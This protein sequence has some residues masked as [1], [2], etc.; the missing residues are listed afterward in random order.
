MTKKKYTC[1]WKYT[2][3]CVYKKYC[4]WLRNKHAFLCEIFTIYLQGIVT[5]DIDWTEHKLCILL[6]QNCK[7]KNV[8]I[9]STFIYEHIVGAFMI[10][11]LVVYM[12]SER[13]ERLNICK[14]FWFDS[15]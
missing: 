7:E 14:N 15:F 9:K 8:C 4:Y 12:K 11:F 5:T 10:G 13:K 1:T 3:T 6:Y 2:C